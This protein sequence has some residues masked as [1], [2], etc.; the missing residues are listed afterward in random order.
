MNRTDLRDDV[1]SPPPEASDVRIFRTI[2]AVLGVPVE[3]LNDE[4]SPDT[5][6]SWDSLNHLNLVMALE[7]EFD[8]SLSPEQALEMRNVAMIRAILRDSVGAA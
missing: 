4:S 6:P 7:G 2:A 3:E 1:W 8:I 5:V